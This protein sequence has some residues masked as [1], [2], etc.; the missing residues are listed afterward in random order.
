MGIQVDDTGIDIIGTLFKGLQFYDDARTLRAE[1][2]LDAN[3][4]LNISGLVVTAVAGGDS[5]GGG[6]G[7]GGAP[8][9][10][11]YLTLAAHPEISAE[12]VL[13]PGDGLQGTD[14]GANSTY[15][16]AVDTSVVRTSR[17]VLAGNGLSGGGALNADVTLSLTTPGTLT[18]STSNASA[19]NHTHAITSSSNPGA[20]AALL[21]TNASGYLQLVRLGLGVTPSF[22]LHVLATTEQARLAYDT[23]NYV[24]LTVSSGGNLTVAPTGDFIF[25]P[26]GNDILPNVNYDLN[27]GA[28]NKKYLTLHAAELWVETLVAQDTIATI[29]GRVIVAPT[30]TLIADLT[31]GATTFDVKHNQ[32]QNGDRVLL[33]ANGLVEWMAVASSA[34]AI[35][36]GYRYTI[37]RNLDGS[38]A[39]DWNAGDAVVNTGQTGSGFIDLYSLEGVTA[40]PL[41]YVYNFNT[42]GSV[43]SANY[44]QSSQ[45]TLFGDSANTSTN[46]AMYFGRIGGTWANL[47]YNIGTAAV[48]T[49]T[50]TWE[51]WNGGAWTSFSP[52]TTDFKIT[53]A[54]STT[55]TASALTSWAATS[56]NGQTAFWVRVRISAFTSWATQPTQV[57]RRVSSQKLQWGPT[58][59]G[60]VRNSSTFN[61]IIEHWAIGNLNG[62]YGY[63]ADTYGVAVGKYST[64]TSYLTADA[65]NG[66]RIMRGAV[67]LGQ[68]EV[69]GDFKIG[70]D[71]SAPASTN[72]IVFNVAQT[73]N[74]ESV[75]VGDLLLGDN[76]ASKANLFWDKSAGRLNFRGGT[77]TQ[78]YVDT[79]GNLVAGNSTLN[80]NGLSI[81]LSTAYD[82][83]RAVRFLD[84]ATVI[85][86]VRGLVNGS[87]RAVAL[88]AEK[89]ASY[90]S[91]VEVYANC[92]SSQTARAYLSA[93]YDNTYYAGVLLTADSAGNRIQLVGKVVEST[94]L[95]ARA[96]NSAAIATTTATW[97]LVTLDSER[98][99]NDTIH[100]TATNTSRLTATTAGVYQIIFNGSFASN[101]TGFRAAVIK[102]NAAGV[103]GGGTTLAA[104]D[105]P[106]VNGDR[107]HICL[108]TL[109]SLG[110][111][112]YVEVFVYQNSG[113]NLNLDAQGNYSPEFSMVRIA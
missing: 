88:A 40:P 71:L 68:W 26:T 108:S 101:S 25:D 107:T 103:I 67:A 21:S 5:G 54:R 78:I 50:L 8:T 45:F 36:G 87:D 19:G 92:E 34:T 89:F 10:A 86:G 4:N 59:A 64:A 53:G 17:Q 28:L 16:L 56:V 105:V 14:A 70:T 69:D 61:D 23:S 96:Y 3:G 49:A 48:Y 63:G 98:F 79:T 60:M 99:D 18:V 27:L 109:Y 30:T 32:M 44:A 38:G 37:T 82:D 1:I 94:A 62:L 52:T 102:L 65:T 57:G 110:A 11:S 43:Y 112:D 74:S 75:D 13:T 81:T 24:S 93:V 66:L 84:G 31:S 85:G 51:F 2:Y 39:N 90:N 72:L 9:N 104:F 76:T 55:W 12:R 73:Y 97:T 58:V 95:G 29:G 7:S 113:G 46:D 80:T 47:Y 111:A 77:T 83:V 42:T 6:G 20:A 22:P 15:T 33:Q 100:S 41:D 35:A 91:M 106:A